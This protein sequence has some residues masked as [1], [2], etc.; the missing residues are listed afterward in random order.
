MVASQ[1]RP[2]KWELFRGDQGRNNSRFLISLVSGVVVAGRK[3]FTI[4]L[5][6]KC[7]F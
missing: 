1:G 4:Q 6:H 5:W 2:S 7:S 3:L